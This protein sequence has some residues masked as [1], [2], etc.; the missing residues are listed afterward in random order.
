MDQVVRSL[1]AW[2]R[3]GSRCGV[4][5]L[6]GLATGATQAVAQDT[7]PL[8]TTPV[9]E[10]AL[11]SRVKGNPA[12]EV[13]VFEIADF[14]CPYCARFAADLGKQLDRKYVRTGRV[15]W[16]FVNLPLHTHRLAW[17]ASEAALCAGAAGG[18]FW[19]MHDRLFAEQQRWGAME[20]P[21][22]FFTRVARELGVDQAEYAA[23]VARDRV[24]P[25]ILQDF[26]SAISAGIDGTPTF[27]IMKGD[28]V[29]ERLVGIHDMAEW[30]RILDR[31]LGG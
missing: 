22:P 31:A 4:L 8:A 30:S 3:G 10:R 25:L 23:C 19:A 18:H 1:W 6:M 29:L 14:Q 16:V 9:I 17:V 2:G 12:A 13:V 24:A 15:Q 27:I 5:I 7:P 26:G 21:G 28:E 11:E 20:D